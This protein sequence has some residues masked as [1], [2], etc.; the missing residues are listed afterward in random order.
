MRVIKH[1]LSI[2]EP[3]HL[4]LIICNAHN[5]PLLIVKVFFMPHPNRTIKV[6]LSSDVAIGDT[7]SQGGLR[8]F[9]GVAHTGKPFG[10]G[11]AQCIIELSSIKSHPKLPMLIEHDRKQRAGFGALSVNP[12][13]NIDGFLLNNAHGNDVANDADAGFP[14]QLSAHIESQTV[15]EL[16]HGQTE[17][18]NGQ[19]V[20]GP[21]LIMR[22]SQ[23]YE[24]S[25]TP[26]GVDSDTFAMV[27]S[28]DGTDAPTPQPT[29]SNTDKTGDDMTLAEALLAI[30]QMKAQLAALEKT[31]EDLQKA[32]DDMA[33]AA[34]KAEDMANEAMVD[35]QLSQAGFI[36][37][38]NGEGFNGI[39]AATRTMLLSAKLDDAKAMIADLRAPTRDDIPDFL[40]SE[41]YPQSGGQ[42]PNVNPMLANAAARAAAAKP[43]I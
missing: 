24:V 29:Q 11:G 16:A 4:A 27:L 25:F 23:C 15:D 36:K 1:Q 26:T 34:K 33:E 40:L 43:Y 37:N 14:W 8:Q 42:Q 2:P 17:T 9:S 18:V 22:N 35:A 38:E 31:N 5:K 7:P 3:H 6:Q 20:T 32:N 39:S 12:T 41:Q 13:L 28:D 30:E 19:V 10:Y 21:M